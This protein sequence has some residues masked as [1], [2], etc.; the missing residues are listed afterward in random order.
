MTFGL[1]AGTIRRTVRIQDAFWPATLVR[2]AHVLGKT[3][4]SAGAV[5]F[6]TQR[7]RAARTRNAWRQRGVMH[8]RRLL[9]GTVAERIA[10]VTRNTD[11]HGGVRDD[12]TFGVCSA[13][14]R[15]RID[16]FVANA[17]QVV[18]TFGVRCAFGSAV[19]RAANERGKT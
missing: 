10:D 18:G 9:Y 1:H 14:A 15:T 13:H 19:G 16:A 11:A 5:L 2:I 17:S 6:A 7:I 8:D 3:D 12:A 4:A